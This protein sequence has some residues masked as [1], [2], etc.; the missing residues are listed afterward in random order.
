VNHSLKSKTVFFSFFLYLLV[1][2]SI[3]VS[4]KI[5]FFSPSG[6]LFFFFLVLFNNYPRANIYC[7]FGLFRLLRLPLLLVHALNLYVMGV[8]QSGSII[9]AGSGQGL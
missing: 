6:S 8:Q 7:R 4:G 5:R 3:A 9:L 2:E 1:V